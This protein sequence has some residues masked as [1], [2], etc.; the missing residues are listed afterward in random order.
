MTARKIVYDLLIKIDEDKAYS[1]II[2]DNAFE[3]A[4]LSQR[5]KAFASALFYGVLERRMTL[6]YLIRF[7]SETEFNKLSINAITLLRMGLYQILYMDSVPDSASVNETVKLAVAD[8]QFKIKG[9]INAILRTFI[10]SGK[11]INLDG[12][13]DIGRL[14]I[15]YSCPKW[16]VK[17][18]INEYGLENAILILKSSLGRPPIYIK[19]NTLKYSVEE[20]FDALKKEKFS[21]EAACLYKDC[22][23]LNK[24]NSI[25]GSNA[26]RKGM[27]HVQD[28]SSQICCHAVNPILNET[29][30]DMCAAPGGKSFTMA[31]LMQGRG[32]VLSFDLYEGR[33]WLLENGAKHLGINIIEA[34]TGDSSVYNKDIPLADRVLCDVPCSGLGV[35]RR[36]PEIKYKPHTFINE[37]PEIQLKILNNSAKYVKAGGTLVYSTCTLNKTEN[38]DVVNQFLSENRDFSPC[39]VPLNIPDLK[40][41]Y[42]HTFFPSNSGGDGFFIATFKK[43]AQKKERI[44]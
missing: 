5:D 2:L 8:K 10:R 41:E 37:F 25:E 34:R 44:I 9:F 13:D 6:D 18:W 23:K 19:I 33:V 28:I 22:L 31:Q 39:V 12:L 1:N 17:K 32:R 11:E 15:K 42:K 20:V 35:I 21:P 3:K 38:D 7:L 26:Y 14:S 40:D 24:G 30:L 43:D 4:K 36:K 16:L 27:F 29:V